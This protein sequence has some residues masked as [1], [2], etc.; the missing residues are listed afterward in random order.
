MFEWES[1]VQEGTF[2]L[3]ADDFVEGILKDAING[4]EEYVAKY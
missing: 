2:N 1:D 4:T 3:A